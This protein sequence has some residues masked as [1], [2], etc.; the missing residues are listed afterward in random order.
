MITGTDDSSRIARHTSS[1][2]TSGSIKSRITRSG[3][4]SRNRSSARLPSAA[5]S[6]ANPSR[7]RLYRIDSAREASSSTTRIRPWPSA[8]RAHL[9]MGCV[10]ELL[11]LAGQ[12]ERDLL[13][14]VNGVIAHP[15]EL[16]RDDHHPDRPLQDVLIVGAGGNL[17]VHAPVQAVHRVVHLG[18]PLGQG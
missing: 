6:T 5:T 16:A 1:P 13:P 12:E 15:L 7:S 2:V 3:P 10:G 4:E 18:E 14:D 8:P 9:R 17:P 11:E